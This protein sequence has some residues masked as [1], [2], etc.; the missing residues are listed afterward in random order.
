MEQVLLTLV[1]ILLVLVLIMLIG[2]A[3]VGW[4]LLQ[5]RRTQADGEPKPED[6][7]HPEVRKRLEE[8]RALAEK[9][10]REA[11][12]HIHVKE[13]SEGM[14]AICGQFF[15]KSCLKTQGNLVFCREHL[16]IYL[17][18]HWSEVHKLQSSP[19]DPE[20]GVALVEWKAKL[21]ADKALPTI[22]Q[23]HY[24]IDVAEDR[25]QSWVVLFARESD[26]EEVGRRLREAAPDGEL[27]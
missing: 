3:V 9:R 15:C 5:Q 14:C 25:I 26:S 13:P 18:A 12:C 20:A 21:W 11:N 6:S 24:K 27:N 19:D 10:T 17:N 8:A 7:Y 1:V 23:T 22:V 16:G 2:I 4:R